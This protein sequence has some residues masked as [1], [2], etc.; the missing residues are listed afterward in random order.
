MQRPVRLHHAVGKEAI[1]IPADAIARASDESE[2]IL[3]D[4]WDDR[5]HADRTSHRLIDDPGCRRI[6]ADLPQ[7]AGNGKNSARRAEQHLPC[8]IRDV[9]VIRS[10]RRARRKRHDGFGIL[11][12]Y[13]PLPAAERTRSGERLRPAHLC[14]PIEDLTNRSAKIE[15]LRQRRRVHEVGPGLPGEQVPERSVGMAQPWPA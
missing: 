2:V 1:G 6:G 3:S 10:K 13:R 9:V 5:G 15:R 4:D 11:E 7:H 14:L 8:E 12:G